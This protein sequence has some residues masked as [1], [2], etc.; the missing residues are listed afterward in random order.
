M[1]LL[2]LFPLVMIG[3]LLMVFIMILDDSHLAHH[4]L[5]VAPSAIYDEKP[6][7]T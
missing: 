6:I 7:T 2:A 1:A 5:Y 3:V 4:E